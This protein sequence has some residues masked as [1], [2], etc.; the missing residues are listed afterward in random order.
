MRA[1]QPAARWSPL[2]TVSPGQRYSPKVLQAYGPRLACAM[3]SVLV[4]SEFA[5]TFQSMILL[6]QLRLEFWEIFLAPTVPPRL[7]GRRSL[8]SSAYNLQAR[9]SCLVLLRQKTPCALALALAITGK[10]M[11]AKIT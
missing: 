4:L 8:W 1:F 3:V 6:T 10:R 7:Y 11:L 2:S 9:L 5:L